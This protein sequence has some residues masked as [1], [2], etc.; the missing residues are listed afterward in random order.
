MRV[1]VLLCCFALCASHAVADAEAR[2]ADYQRA[3]ELLRQGRLTQAETLTAGLADY[4]LAVYL[5]K[6]RLEA[7]LAKT[8]PAVIRE[9]LQREDGSVAAD[10]LR[11]HWLR[12][13]AQ[14]GQWQAFL[15]NYREL[16][17][18][19]LRCQRLEALFQ[20]G[21]HA[22]ALVETTELWMSSRSLPDACDAPFKRWLAEGQQTQP[23]IWGRLLLA[24]DDGNSRL[25]RYLVT[26][27]EVKKR[28]LGQRLLAVDRHP[29]SLPTQLTGVSDPTDAADI[30]ALGLR[31]LAPVDLE[32]AMSWLDRADLGGRLYGERRSKVLRA[33]AA[34]YIASGANA[35]PWLLRQDPNG[36]DSWL[37]DWRIRLALREANWLAA[38]HWIALLPEEVQQDPRWRYW[39]ARATQLSGGD[40]AQPAAL[41]ALEQLAEE[42]HYYGFLA[43]S[44]LG[45]PLQFN[46]RPDRLALSLEEWPAL[47]RAQEFYL[48]GQTQAAW[49][50]WRAATLAMTPEQLGAAAR[51][52][53]TWGW[54]DRAIHTAVAA[55]GS[56]DLQVRF[57][58]AY[59]DSFQKAA[60]KLGLAPSLLFAV[61]RQESAFASHV[62]SPAGALGLMQLMP[63]TAH[64]VAGDA[65]LAQSTL[66]QP[67]ENIRLGSRYLASLLET[68]AGNRVLAAAAYNAGPQRISRV[69]ERQPQALPFDIWIETLP[70]YETRE[71]VKGILSFTAIY[72]YRLGVA[73]RLLSDNELRIGSPET[74]LTQ[75]AP[76]PR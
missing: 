1:V 24:L 27:L 6:A 32:L 9:F 40:D 34:E 18:T 10:L 46:D 68:F 7:N 65:R 25:A 5:E 53:S 11:E 3:V 63:T 13:L 71:Y 60:D 74:L 19:G 48:M 39:S 38:R 69:L 23:L 33:L 52:A 67:E 22:Q 8:S 45:R 72:D 37:L 36:D 76:A 66:L 43:A 21:A 4:P 50:E 20:S 49:R 17:S 51:L 28:A 58:L 62:R 35:L 31:R 41:A 16:P 57:P 2:R 42:R 14:R 61:A 12:M 70:Y 75:V 44:R 15:D 47:R 55:G 54:H 26:R 30:I 56:D 29:A 73:P 64:R 59:Q